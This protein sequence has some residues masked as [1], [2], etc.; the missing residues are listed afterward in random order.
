M[1]Q[2]NTPRQHKAIKRNLYFTEDHEW[3]DFQGS[4]AY[5]GVC[6]FKLKGIKVIQKIDFAQNAQIYQAGDI[7]G[8]IYYEEYKV[9]IHIPVAARVASFNE[10]HLNGDRKVLIDQPEDNGWFA[11][12]VPTM[13]YERKGLLTPQQYQLKEKN[14]W[15]S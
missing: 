9:D 8:S 7:I 3:I 13:P 6:K 4:V 15:Q 14:P 2:P 1:Q 10:E 12:I 5:V 11:L